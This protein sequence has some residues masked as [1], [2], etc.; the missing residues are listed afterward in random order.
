M[1]GAYRSQIPRERISRTAAPHGYRDKAQA[2]EDDAMQKDKR[3]AGPGVQSGW[4]LGPTCDFSGCTG[5][6]RHDFSTLA[7]AIE[8]VGPLL[9]HR[10]ALLKELRTVVCAAQAV[11]DAVRELRLDD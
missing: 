3:P 7:Q 2:P 6:Q 9:H 5:M 10:A 1:P 4:T 11:P 8:V